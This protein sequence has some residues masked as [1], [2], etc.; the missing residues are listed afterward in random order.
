[1]LI[2]ILVESAR[3]TAML[4]SI[5][6]GAMVFT[7][8]VNFTSMPAD[9]RDFVVQFSPTP[10]LV[11]VVMMGIYLLLGMIMEELAIV[12]LTIPVFFPV[13]VGLGFDPVWFGILIVTIVEI[14][15]I[16]PPV[17]LNL[18]VLNSLLPNINLAI[19]YRGIWP[20]VWADV[21]RLAIL[22]AFPIIS[23]WLPGMMR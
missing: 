22:M 7:S 6:I 9:L 1:V 14:G 16:S 18:F 23:L 15:M 13:I 4:F 17:G 2:D 19:L 11:V 10:I 3:T 8:F 12:L 20:F 21:V 5:L